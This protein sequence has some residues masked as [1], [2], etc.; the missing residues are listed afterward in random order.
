MGREKSQQ[1]KQR[2]E[3]GL[4]IKGRKVKRKGEVKG[5]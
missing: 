5:K 1:E 4:G 3:E 2:K